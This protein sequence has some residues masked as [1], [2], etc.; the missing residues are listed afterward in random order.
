[1][2]KQNPALKGQLQN[3]LKQ[4]IQASLQANNGNISATAQVLGISR[5]TLY[6]K[7]KEN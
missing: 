1:M 5:T 6:K 3:A 7:L 2:T 4:T